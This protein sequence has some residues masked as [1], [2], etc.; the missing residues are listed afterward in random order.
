LCY[1]V[2]NEVQDMIPHN[3]PRAD[4]AVFAKNAATQVAAGKVTN[5]L[6][7]QAILFSTLLSTVA[8]DLAV[9]D[10]EQVELRAASIAATQKAQDAARRAL[11]Y[12][13]LL[14]YAMKSADSP[15]DQFDVVGFNPPATSRQAVNPETPDGLAA[16]GSSNG[17]NELSF[18]GNNTPNSVTYVIQ[19]KMGEAADYA[20]VGLSRS[21]RF[22]HIGVTPGV[23]C[24]YRV[25]AEAARGRVSDWSNEAVVYGRS[26]DTPIRSADTPVRTAA[27]P[28]NSS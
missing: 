13:Q 7:D 3:M 11:K 8:D 2:F 20:I 6:P 19:A 25:R 16:E 26:A 10:A 28:P 14:K 4:L 18:N 15:A 22:K 5:L 21:Q 24:Q 1:Y 17:V 27:Q 9:A 12:I 23:M